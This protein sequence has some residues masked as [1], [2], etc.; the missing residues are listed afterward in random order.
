MVSDAY[1]AGQRRRKESAPLAVRPPGQRRSQS[2]RSPTPATTS[3]REASSGSTKGV[4]PARE[5]AADTEAGLCRTR[6]RR[7][8]SK[9]SSTISPSGDS[10][11]TA[12]RRTIR[13]LDAT[14]RS[15]A[16][17]TPR[18]SA[19]QPHDRGSLAVGH[20]MHQ[21]TVI[22]HTNLYWGNHEAPGRTTT[23]VEAKDVDFK[24]S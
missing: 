10:S 17:T 22:A 24:A 20:A 6:S 19:I 11:S 3:P 15:C 1:G 14:R 8:R 2:S 12:R 13:A 4:E 18:R 21:D 7:R 16:A 23:T 9:R 5:R